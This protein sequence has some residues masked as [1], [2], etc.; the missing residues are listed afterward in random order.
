MSGLEAT[1]HI[2][3]IESELGVASSVL[4][5]GLTGN[6]DT[7]SLNAYANAGLN[8]CIPKGTFLPKALQKALQILSENPR[9]F[10]ELRS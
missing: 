6:T 2:R 3:R 1:E 5:I 7:D 9:Q 8:G 4:I 10:A